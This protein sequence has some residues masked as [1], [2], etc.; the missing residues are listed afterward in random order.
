MSTRHLRTA[1]KATNERN[2]KVLKSLLQQPDNKYCADCRKKDPRWAS[3]NIGV[4]VCIRCSGVHR[5]M[6]TH[7]SK[8]KSVDLDTWL[9]DQVE[10]M[11]K[12]GNAR[13]ALYWEANLKDRKP[14]E[15]NIDGW[16]RAKYEHKRW[17]MKGP[18]PDP[19]TLGDGSETV[20]AT[21]QPS[22]QVQPVVAPKPKSSSDFANLDAFLGA[23][24]ATHRVADSSS[25][26]NQLHGANFFSMA[27]EEIRH[28]S[29]APVTPA[30]SRPDTPST[31]SIKSADNGG[32]K[33][34][35]LKS[36][37]LSLYNSP[38]ANASAGGL[39]TQPTTSY[40]NNLGNYQQQLSG[41]AMGPPSGM[42]P[43]PPPQQANQYQNVWGGF[44]EG[45]SQQA[46]S[47]NNDFTSFN[48]APP[49][50]Q[51]ILQTLSGQILMLLPILQT[52]EVSL[53]FLS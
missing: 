43:Q 53:I 28:S 22:Q 44:Q 12:W 21:A 16:I 9:P 51:Q 50:F 7:I 24:S 42:I 48:Q 6:G 23:P 8:V 35:N 13:A 45:S 20:S 26:P 2:T 33:H 32:S 52:L 38:R 3:W 11:V 14:S 1:D 47:N 25:P 40:A 37:I 46:W 5:S 49:A 27:D 18:V 39:S 17:A 19:S 10:N 34:N 30:Q 31:A 36:S 4:F 15:S 29:S 41:L